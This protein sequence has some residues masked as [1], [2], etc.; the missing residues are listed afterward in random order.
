MY[1]R[2][3]MDMEGETARRRRR[4]ALVL[5]KG[6]EVVKARDITGFAKQHDLVAANHAV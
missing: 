2:S 5:D 4:F 6:N 3:D 1:R